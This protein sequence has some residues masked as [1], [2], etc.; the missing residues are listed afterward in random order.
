MRLAHEF[1]VDNRLKYK[2]AVR[3]SFAANIILAILQVYAAAS[4]GSLSLL[5]TMADTLFD[6][7]SNFT[8]I[9]SNRAV[10]RVDP[11]TFPSGKARIETVGNIVQGLSGLYIV[12]VYSFLQL[13]NFVS[14]DKVFS[15]KLIEIDNIYN[16]IRE[17]LL[18]NAISVELEEVDG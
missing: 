7:L 4:S 5:T 11:R 2:I 9:L 6:P 12:E 17:N 18:S 15:T 1:Q 8:L 16:S 10:K 3:G 14:F 13:A